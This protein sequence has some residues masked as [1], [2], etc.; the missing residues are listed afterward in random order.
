MFYSSD[1]DK[2]DPFYFFYCE[3]FLSLINIEVRSIIAPLDLLIGYYYLFL[4]I[5][6]DIYFKFKIIYKY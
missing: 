5:S 3:I 1:H 2:A 4:I 6:D